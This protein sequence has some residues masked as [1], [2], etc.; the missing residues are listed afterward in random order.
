MWSVHPSVIQKYTGLKTYNLGLINADFADN[1]L[2]LYLY[3][4][5]NKAPK[6]LFLYVSPESM[7][8]TFNIFNTCRFA[9]F[10][11]DS[12]IDAVVKECDIKY[13]DWIKIPF[14]KY[15]H[16]NNTINFDVLQGLKHF[17]TNRNV[18]YYLDNGYEPPFYSIKVNNL[19]SFVQIY[20]KGYNFVWN[21]SREKWLRKIIE[22][23]Q[24]QN[25]N[26]YL[27]E[28]P[29]L[30]KALGNLPNRNETVTKI[31]TIANEYGI[32]FVQFENMKI[33]DSAK[34]FIST[35]S[36]TV[37]GNVIFSDS[38]GRYIKNEIVKNEKIF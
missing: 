11:G 27:Y 12:V 10:I 3:L 31:S 8:S 33:A 30:K 37:K 28:S 14:M 4:K 36:M 34:Y 24:L 23:A 13:F 19:N 7:D 16:Y 2:H 38:L 17:L 26:V 29:L 22:F 5:H 15:A 25:I 20:P 18:P 9:R 21:A 1:Y 35:V 6:Y 32:K